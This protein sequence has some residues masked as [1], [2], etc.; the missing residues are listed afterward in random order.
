MRLI[1]NLTTK[2]L[3]A[4]LEIR[5]RNWLAVSLKIG[6]FRSLIAVPIE[7]VQQIW[8]AKMDFGWPNAEIGQKMASG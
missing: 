5:I 6:Y 3:I 8:P 7:N 1:T 2:G 4:V